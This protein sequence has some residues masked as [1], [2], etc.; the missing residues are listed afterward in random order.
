RPARV[1]ASAARR[2]R[3]HPLVSLSARGGARQHH[4][5]RPPLGP[6]ARPPRL[7]GADRGRPRTSRWPPDRLARRRR[8][9]RAALTRTHLHP[10]APALPEPG[11]PPAARADAAALTATPAP[12]GAK[13]AHPAPAPPESPLAARDRPRPPTS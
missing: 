7:R 1:L 6:A 12:P 5:P 13:P 2:A 3:P 4:P 11:P 10:Q 9:R 8:A